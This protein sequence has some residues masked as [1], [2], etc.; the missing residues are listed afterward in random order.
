MS[1]WQTALA[2]VDLPEPELP[3]NKKTRGLLG[4]G[5]VP[6]GKY[7]HQRH[8]RNSEAFRSSS[9]PFFQCVLVVDNGL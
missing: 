6:K 3:V 4:D 9:P 8:I 1:P 5:S 2:I 7:G